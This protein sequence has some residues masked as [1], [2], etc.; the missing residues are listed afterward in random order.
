M[1][2]SECSLPCMIGVL[3][4]YCRP[5]GFIVGVHMNLVCRRVAAGTGPE[6]GDRRWRR[7]EDKGRKI[8]EYLAFAGRFTASFVFLSLH[9]RS[10]AL[11][12]NVFEPLLAQNRWASYYLV[13]GPALP[14]T[15]YSHAEIRFNSIISLGSTGTRSL[16]YPSFH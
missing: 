13:P 6:V 7:G 9:V 3:T 15:G 10:P 12:H 5:S 14:G 16:F 1:S 2:P 11:I 8:L 4:L